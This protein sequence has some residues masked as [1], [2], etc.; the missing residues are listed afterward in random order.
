G[1]FRWM[2]LYTQRKQGIEGARTSK[3]S[4]DELQD[5]YF[6]TRVRIDGGALTTQ[7]LRVIAGVSTEF[8]R[9]SADVSDR[10]NVQHHRIR[11]DH[12]PEIRRRFDALG[13][14]TMDACGDCPRVVLGSPVAGVAA[15][16]IVDPT[17]AIEEIRD[18]YIG[19]PEFSNLPRKYKTA[20]TG[21]PSLDVVHEIN[22]ISFV[23]VVHPELGAGF[24]L[25]V[26]G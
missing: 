8:A 11:I 3:L 16:E 2:G 7:Q 25:W 17:P 5:E 19:S 4:A 1:R 9:T 24:D 14:T 22:D 10:Q 21:H 26:G 15:D 20:F 23:G 13:L 18:K 6:M 12:L